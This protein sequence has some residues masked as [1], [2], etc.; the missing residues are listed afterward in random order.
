MSRE[1]DY[2]VE[3]YLT[4]LEMIGKIRDLNYESSDEEIDKDR[5]DTTEAMH[6]GVKAYSRGQR[7][8]STGKGDDLIIMSKNGIDNTGESM[9]KEMSDFESKRL[10]EHGNRHKLTQ[11]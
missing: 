11:D 7:D 1:N 2:D 3:T 4:R 9:R 8:I 5:I 10:K 6:I